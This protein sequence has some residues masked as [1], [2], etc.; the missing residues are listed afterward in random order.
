MSPNRAAD[1]TFN[2]LDPFEDSEPDILG[3]VKDA[4][5]QAGFD[6]GVMY[7]AH[8]SC[9]SNSTDECSSAPRRMSISA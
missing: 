5:R 4:M 1:S 7:A 2:S 3:R 9:L 8:Q 6:V